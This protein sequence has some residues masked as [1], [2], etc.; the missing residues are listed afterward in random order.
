MN[1]K[2]KHSN[3]TQILPEMEF[4]PILRAE[5]P[6]YGNLNRPA[7][8]AYTLADSISQ[9]ISWGGFVSILQPNTQIH[10]FKLYEVVRIMDNEILAV[11][12][13]DAS[14]RYGMIVAEAE[15]DAKTNKKKNIAVCLFCP[16]F[17]FPIGKEPSGAVLDK[18]YLD[19]SGTTPAL[20][21]TSNGRVLAVKTG[22]RSIFFSGTAS[23]FGMVSN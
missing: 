2:I 14:Y 22:T 5:A 19:L 18:L 1:N 11:S 23:I 8:S 20:S 9:V 4:K 12:T 17:V 21:H 6:Y 3:P 13:L 7:Q 16:N 10:D 15:I